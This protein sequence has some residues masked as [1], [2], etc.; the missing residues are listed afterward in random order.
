MSRR[1]LRAVFADQ[2]L[3]HDARFLELGEHR[4]HLDQHF[5]RLGA[6]QVQLSR[7]SPAVVQAYDLGTWTSP[8]GEA[9]T[10]TVMEWL[11][12]TM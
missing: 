3:E 10:Y 1:V 5:A 7:R 12:A 9:V 2:V 11:E 8:R 4:V 6:L